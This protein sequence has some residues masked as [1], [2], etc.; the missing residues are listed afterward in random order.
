MWQGSV[1]ACLKPCSGLEHALQ[2]HAGHEHGSEDR[3]LAR[4][5]VGRLVVD[6]Q[7][8]VAL[9]AAERLLDLPAPGLDLEP[10]AAD[11][12]DQR[13]GDA[14]GMQEGSRVVA[15]EGAIQL[16]QEQGR[17]PVEIRGEGMERIAILHVGRHDLYPE[18]V[19]LGIDH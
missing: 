14:V 2:A 7:A 12:A 6:P 17:M 11:G 8:A 9:Q 15:G 19:A 1:R 4:G 13:G 3:H 5:V 16:D 18:R 10:L